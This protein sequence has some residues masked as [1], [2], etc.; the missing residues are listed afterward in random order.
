[1]TG[2]GVGFNNAAY[3]LLVPYVMDK[4]GLGEF[5]N[6]F[7]GLLTDKSSATGAAAISQFRMLDG[8][9]GLSIAASLSTPQVRA[10][11]L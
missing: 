6:Y 4:K 8:L 9:I 10:Q 2:L 1:M 3:T 11:L 7:N 5:D